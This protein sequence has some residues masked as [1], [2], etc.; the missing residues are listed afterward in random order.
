[1]AKATQP[2]FEANGGNVRIKPESTVTG[3]PGA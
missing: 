3:K 2:A 1:M